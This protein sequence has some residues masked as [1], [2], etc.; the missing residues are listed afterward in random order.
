MKK[1]LVLYCMP[2]AGLQEWTNKPE[3]ERKEMEEKMKAEWDAWQAAHQ[4]HLL[5]TA[6]AGATVEVRADGPKDTHNDVMMY[7]LVQIESKEAAT[8]MFVGH[9]HLAISGA[10]IHIMEANVL[11]GMS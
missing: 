9:P 2:Y 11:P 6:G 4:Q 1:F 5:E 3:E 10:W 8:E 7:S